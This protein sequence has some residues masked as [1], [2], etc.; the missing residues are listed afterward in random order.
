MGGFLVEYRRNNTPT[1]RRAYSNEAE[2][3]GFQVGTISPESRS[4]VV[5]GLESEEF[6]VVRVAGSNGQGVGGFRETG[7]LLLSHAIGVP[8]PPTI[9]KVIGWDEGKVTITTTVTKFGSRM[10]FSLNS[11]LILNGTETPADMM[12]TGYLLV[13]YT[14]GEEVE[15]MLVNASYRGDLRFAVMASNYLGSSPQSDPSLKGEWTVQCCDNV[16]Y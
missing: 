14:L 2:G 1:W 9:P 11:I 6:Y 15:L 13:N 3:G 5:F 7:K 4:H 8:S 16:F 12:G 10:N